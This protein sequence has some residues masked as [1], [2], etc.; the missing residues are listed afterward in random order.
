MQQEKENRSI[1]G[2]TNPQ[3]QHFSPR[4]EGK[5]EKGDSDSFDKKEKFFQEKK[6]FLSFV[7]QFLFLD[8]FLRRR[9]L[10]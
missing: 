8:V 2:M 3:G 10:K 5:K 4:R 9:H 7:T 6:T 1:F